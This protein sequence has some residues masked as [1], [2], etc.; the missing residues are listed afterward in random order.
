MRKPEI[1]KI[2]KPH[3]AV[4]YSVG[5]VVTQRLGHSRQTGATVGS[6]SLSWSHG[7]GE[8]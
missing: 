2:R 7:A 5:G 3:A 6:P 8:A 1:R 4:G